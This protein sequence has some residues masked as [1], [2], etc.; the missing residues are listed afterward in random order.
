MK[1]AARAPRET[2][3]VA[4]TLDPSAPLENE[5]LER[6]GASLSAPAWQRDT[7]SVSARVRA[8]LDGLRPLVVHVLSFWDHAVRAVRIAGRRL[9]VDPSGSYRLR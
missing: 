9:E 6:I 2:G 3:R 5:S 8:I 7:L 4:V 1:E